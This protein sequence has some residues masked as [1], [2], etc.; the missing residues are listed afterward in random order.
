VKIPPPPTSGRACWIA[1]SKNR[2]DA[3]FGGKA[4]APA[5]CTCELSI[6]SSFDDELRCV[7]LAEMIVDDG[8]SPPPGGK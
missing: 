2:G 6:A 5:V 8:D 3:V 1:C 7:A 4:A